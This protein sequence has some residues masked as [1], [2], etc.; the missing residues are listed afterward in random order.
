MRRFA[1]AA[2]MIA[3]VIFAFAATSPVGADSSPPWVSQRP[4]P[5]IIQPSSP[6]IIPGLGQSTLPTVAPAPVPVIQAPRPVEAV[7][8]RNAVPVKRK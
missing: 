5:P 8:P 4:A 6:L 7:R 2:I 1:S 3:A